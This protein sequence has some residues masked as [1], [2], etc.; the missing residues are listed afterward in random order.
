MFVTSA[1]KPSGV[2]CGGILAKKLCDQVAK[3]VVVVCVA[4]RDMLLANMSK[5]N[6]WLQPGSTW[7]FYFLEP[8][9]IMI[10]MYL[11]TLAYMQSCG[12][13][14]GSS[15]S[16]FIDGLVYTSAHDD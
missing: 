7:G 11:L 12:H 6:H 3:V 8:R 1:S 9:A 14:K 10:H 5:G 4:V 13:R 16:A 15:V 2:A